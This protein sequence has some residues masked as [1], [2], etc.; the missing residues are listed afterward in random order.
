M[1][2]LVVALGLAACAAAGAATTS[3]PAMARAT[4]L[5]QGDV[6]SGPLALSQSMHIVVGL[7]LQNKAELDAYISKPGFKPLTGAQFVAR[8]SPSEAQARAVANFLKASGFTNVKISPNRI[9]VSG[10]AS[11]ANAA[12]AFET[13]LVSVKTH[14]GR[15]AYANSTDAKVPASMQ[16][17]VNGVVGLQNVHI[18]HLFYREYTGN[19]TNAVTGHQPTDFPSIYGATSLPVPTGINIGILAEGNLSK[20]LTSLTN[21]TTANGLPAVTTKSVGTPTS[22]TSGTLEWELDSQTIVGAAGGQVGSLT[23]YLM[24]NISSDTGVVDGIN[25]AVTDNTTTIVNGSLGV[26]EVDAKNDGSFAT[27]DAALQQGIAQGQ[28]FSFSTGDDGASSCFTL[29]TNSGCWPATSAYVVAVGGTTLDASTGSGATWNSEKVW[30][31][32]GGQQS[33]V[34]AKPS[35]QTLWSGT[36]RATPDIAFD[37]DPSSGALIYNGSRQTQVGGTSLSS[38]MFVGFWAR[39]MQGKGN[40]GFPA[41]LMYPLSASDFHDITQGSNGNPAGPGYDLASGRGSVIWSAA[42]SE[43]SGGGN[44]PPVASFTSRTRGLI[45]Q[46]TDTSTDPDGTIVARLWKFGDGK[47]G[48]KSPQLHKYASA[49]TYTVTLTV[50]D[51]DG[52]TNSTSQSV[53]VP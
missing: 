28:S 43:L 35:W 33:Q 38:P 26:S 45:V 36:N 47:Q 12:R 24:P 48:T 44:Q 22:D 7:K 5:A 49:G 10:D 15:V 18:P 29:H 2:A 50:K 37:A 27:A 42:Y 51:N 21:F 31:S 16:S 25:L 6:V 13:S 34:E 40:L 41:P 11:A 19:A 17:F 39:V 53:T 20:T 32:A 9:L 8:Y 14:D 46:L 30:S 4:R 1:K 23:F 3:S 52:A